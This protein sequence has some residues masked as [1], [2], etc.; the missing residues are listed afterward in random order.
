[1]TISAPLH[2]RDRPDVNRARELTPAW[3]GLDL[4]PS[5]WVPSDENYANENADFC[6]NRSYTRDDF[7]VATATAWSNRRARAGLEPCGPSPYPFVMAGPRQKQIDLSNRP[8]DLD[9]DVYDE[10]PDAEVDIG[11]TTV[12]PR[13]CLFG[14]YPSMTYK[15]G[16]V[17]TIKFRAFPTS[18]SDGCDPPST[19]R[20]VRIWAYPR[21]GWTSGT[22]V[23]AFGVMLPPPPPPP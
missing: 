1:L 8:V 21:L 10:D 17:A 15:D 19:A 3:R 12:G 16:D 9:V 23:T 11:T 20:E 2:G 13:A 18:P 14:F 4:D 22:S 5:I 7:P 6:D